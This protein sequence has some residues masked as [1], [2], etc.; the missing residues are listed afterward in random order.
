MRVIKR[1]GRSELVDLNKVTTRIAKLCSEI[2]TTVIDPI[3]IS[4]KVCNAL[5]FYLLQ[6]FFASVG[7]DHDSTSIG[8]AVCN[9]NNDFSVAF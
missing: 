2:E 9:L 7:R 5:H 1:D 8:S 3:V 6:R 4:Q